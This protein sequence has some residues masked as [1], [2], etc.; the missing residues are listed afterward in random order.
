MAPITFPNDTIP[1][2][3]F[4]K[5]FSSNNIITKDILKTKTNKNG[6]RVFAQND[7]SL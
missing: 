6:A 4:Q 7:N 2:S 3:I 1:N 5:I